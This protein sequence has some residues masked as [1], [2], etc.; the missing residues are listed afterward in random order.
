MNPQ[1]LALVCVAALMVTT[2]VISLIISDASIVDITWGLGFAVVGIATWLADDSRTSLDHLITV[3]VVV[4]GLRLTAYLAWRNLGHGEDFRYRA[5]RRRWGSSFWIMSLLTVYVLQGT[6][7]WMVSLPVHLS[8]RDSAGV[9]ALA[10]VGTALW[11]VG[12]LFES[13]G[14]LQ[15]ARFKADSSNDGKVMNSGLW[16]YTRHPNYFG[17]ACVWWGIAL[18]AAT[19][20]VGRWGLIGAFVMNVLLLRVSGVAMLEKSLV[21]RKP[22]YE[23]YI[24][25]TSAFIPRPP[26]RVVN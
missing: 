12:L 3:L 15:L 10:I 6:L 9:G 21:K 26:R 11:G 25:R 19:T 13:V 8:H 1:L 7:M 2:W 14:D 23:E 5:M 22:Q 4:W 20:G 18:V 17:D 24:A 16:K